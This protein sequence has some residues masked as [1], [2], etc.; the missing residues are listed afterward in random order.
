MNL[1]L[2]LIVIGLTWWLIGWLGSRLYKGYFY[3]AYSKVLKDWYTRE[4]KVFDIFFSVLGPIVWI[5]AYFQIRQWNR[6]T[7]HKFTWK[8]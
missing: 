2:L 5:Q 6:E 3:V 7:G 8:W 1:E 4:D